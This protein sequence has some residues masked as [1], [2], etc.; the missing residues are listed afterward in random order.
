MLE[1][2]ITALALENPGAETPAET[3]QR[4]RDSFPKGATRRMTQLG[5]IV[6]HTLGQ[7]A[8]DAPPAVVYASAFA[9]SRALEGFLDSFPTASPTL[10]QTSIHPSA[11]QQ[12]L[13]HRHQP[14]DT[15]L[16]VA[17]GPHLAA[18]ALVTA[19]LTGNDRDVVYCGGE[20]RGT[21]LL[22]HGACSERTFAFALRLAP[23]AAVDKRPRLARLRLDPS[24]AAA[25][26]ATPPL[27]LAAWFDALATRRDLL[28]PLPSG[29]QVT[30]EWSATS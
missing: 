1:R 28:V 2:H 19:M 26:S 25:P 16:P 30:L 5:L 6:G 18:Q 29:G 12:A 8:P 21:W 10:F 14:V 9:E 15:F 11:V 22:E 24:P 7:V 4:L 17:G 27:S 13:I 23:V 20:E 3:R